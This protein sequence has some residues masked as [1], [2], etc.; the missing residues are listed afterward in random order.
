ML[1]LL[2]VVDK[3]IKKINCVPIYR[4]HTCMYTNKECQTNSNDLIY[5]FNYCYI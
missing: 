4:V 1:C 3:K 2:L 5:N